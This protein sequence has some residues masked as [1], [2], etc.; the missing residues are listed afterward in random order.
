MNHQTIQLTKGFSRDYCDWEVNIHA[1]ISHRLSA[2]MDAA[3]ELVRTISFVRS[4]NIAV[5]PDF[6][7]D[8]TER[9]L[10]DQCRYDVSHIT[11]YA[12]SFVFYLQAKWDSHFQAEYIEV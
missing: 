3:K 11:V 6:L 9:L 8:E 10:Q 1:K 2:Q 4:I 7:S 5:P 12:R